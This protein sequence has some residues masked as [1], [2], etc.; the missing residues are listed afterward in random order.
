MDEAITPLFRFWQPRYWPIWIGVALLR[1]V[2]MLP[3][4]GQL[5]VARR[6]GGILRVVLPKRRHIA[7]ANLAICFPELNAT[8]QRTMLRRWA[9][10]SLNLFWRG[11]Q[12]TTNWMVYFRST[13]SSMCTLPSSKAVAYFFLAVI[14]RATK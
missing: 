2:V 8:E 10:P 5:W 11:G 6:I 7:Q 4:R 14:S 1:L 3:C 9:C 12:A 13:A